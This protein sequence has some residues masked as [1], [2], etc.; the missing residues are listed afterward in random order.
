[1]LTI[2]FYKTKSLFRSQKFRWVMT[3]KNNRIVG[4][5]TEGFTNRADC[6]TNALLVTNYDNRISMKIVE[7]W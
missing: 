3:A 6:H 5:S 1:M 7:M 2:K 4:A